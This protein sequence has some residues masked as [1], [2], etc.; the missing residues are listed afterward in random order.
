MTDLVA[1]I[2]AL[3]M[4]LLRLLSAQ[5]EPAPPAPAEVTY[6]CWLPAVELTSV[7]HHPQPILP[8][9][10]AVGW[11]AVVREE[12]GAPVVVEYDGAADAEHLASLDRRLCDY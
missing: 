12:G 9:E 7:G 5:P 3:I 8:D 6:P 4:V 11:A 10:L 1:L 2:M